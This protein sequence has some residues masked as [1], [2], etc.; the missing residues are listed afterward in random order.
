MNLIYLY[1][2]HRNF[3]VEQLKTDGHYGLIHELVRRGIID[4]ARIIMDNYAVDGVHVLEDQGGVTIESHH[5]LDTVE[6]QAG[7]VIYVRAAWKPWIPW[8][9]KYLPDHWIMHYDANAG[10]KAWPYWDVELFDLNEENKIGQGGKLWWHYRKPISP[11]FKNLDL[12][13]PSQFD[14]CVGASHIYDRKGQ[15]RI[16]PIA[17]KFKK[18]TGRDLKIVMPGCYYSHERQTQAMRAEINDGKWPNIWMP[19]W[20]PRAEMVEVYNSAKFFYAATCGGQGDR[21]VP[22]SGTC[23]C[24]QII[25]LPK[26]HP[27]YAYSNPLISY[28]PPHQDDFEAIAR[29]LAED[30][31]DLSRSA[32]AEYFKHEAGMDTAIRILEPLFFLFREKKNRELLKEL[33]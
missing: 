3:R 32:V 27:P 15:F 26:N 7:D 21:C 24:R 20:L 22:E 13:E 29:Y 8:I 31:N 33:V 28:I 5:S 18:L 10:R 11:E 16:L 4:S 9:E 14:V 30:R 6:P 25:G 12:P 2:R 19:G 1:V 23:G 17:K